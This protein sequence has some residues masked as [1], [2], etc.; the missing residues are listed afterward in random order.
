MDKQNKTGCTVIIIIFIAGVFMAIYFKTCFVDKPST[1]KSINQPQLELIN[2]NWHEDYGYAKVEGMVKNLTSET[3][4]TVE[5]VSNFYTNDD[6][7]IASDST[8]IEYQALLPGQSSPFKALEKWNPEM[9]KCS[10]EFKTF[11]GNK[12][13]TKFSESAS[14]LLLK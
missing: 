14:K 6:K 1:S 10:I 3:L 9:T 12:I 13:N 8:L 2:W 11:G 5:V 4:N 7:F